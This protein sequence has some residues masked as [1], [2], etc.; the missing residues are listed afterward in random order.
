MKRFLFTLMVLAAG[1]ILVIEPK[2]T[3]SP[4][5]YRVEAHPIEDTVHVIIPVTEVSE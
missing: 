4:D 2:E 3:V 5:Y 1:I